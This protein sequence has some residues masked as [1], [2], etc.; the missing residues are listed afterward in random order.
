VPTRNIVYESLVLR[1]RESPG[2]DRILCLMTAEA[3]IQDVF[4]FGG[5]KSK[6]RSLASPYSS[7]RA[8][9]Y[10]DPSR[11]FRKLSDF[12]VNES[13]TGLREGLKKIWAAGLVA[14]FLLKTNGGGGDFP[15]VLSLSREAMRGLESCRDE[16]AD[17][18][19]LLYLWRMIDILG[20]LPEAENCSACGLPFPPGAERL[21][22]FAAGGFL[23]PACARAE[24]SGGSEESGANEGL[25]RGNGSQGWGGGRNLAEF[26]NYVLSAGAARWLSR[27]ASLSF[28]EASKVGLD[29]A[30]LAGLKA[31]VFGLARSAADAPLASLSVGAGIL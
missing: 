15:E 2:G 3:G 25:S 13:F 22:S 21:Y 14:E 8:F 19:L 18:P 11:D 5:P 9:V 24:Q 10:L 29:A 12:E 20:L 28:A 31:L 6:L 7:G 27:S 30:S 17:F 16:E 23:C 26:P 4:V 1:A